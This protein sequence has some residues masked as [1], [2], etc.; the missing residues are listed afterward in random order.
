MQFTSNQDH[1]GAPGADRAAGQPRRPHWLRILACLAA[2]AALAGAGP[3]QSGVPGMPRSSEM[4]NPQPNRLPDANQQMEMREQQAKQQNFDAA[5]A[6][7]KKQI[8]EDSAKLLKLATELKA[9]V[10]KTTKD[11]LS[12]NVIRKADEIEKLAHGVKE[13]MKLTIGGS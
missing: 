11:T 3:G 2:L 1:Q 8:A 12:L 7:R 6:E 5:N 4:P 9:E 10:D 13:K